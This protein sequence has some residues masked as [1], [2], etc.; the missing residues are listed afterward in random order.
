MDDSSLKALF[1]KLSSDQSLRRRLFEALQPEEHQMATERRLLDKETRE[2]MFK[3]HPVPST[4][5]M[6]TPKVD[7]FMLSM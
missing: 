2:S 3:A 7:E 5:V 4:P 6:K 1:D